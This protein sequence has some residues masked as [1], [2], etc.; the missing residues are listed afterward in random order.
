MDILLL[1]IHVPG[2]PTLAVISVQSVLISY[3]NIDLLI[4]CI[5]DD[6]QALVWDL[7]Q[8]RKFVQDPILCYSARQEINHISWSKTMTDWVAVATGE[9]VEALRI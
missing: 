8:M 1:S 7:N 9:I 2:H 5:G 4:L 3:I 6:S